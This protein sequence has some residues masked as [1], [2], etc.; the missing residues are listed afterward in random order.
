VY[1]VSVSGRQKIYAGW[2]GGYPNHYMFSESWVYASATTGFHSPRWTLSKHCLHVNQRDAQ[3]LGTKAYPGSYK[4]PEGRY[5]LNQIVLVDPKGKRY[6]NLTS[7]SVV[8]LRPS[9]FWTVQ[10]DLQHNYY[11]GWSEDSGN[12]TLLDQMTFRIGSCP[13]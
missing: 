4:F 1:Q 11:S 10:I 6:T 2:D 8:R 12:W 13:P 7:G 5:P 9:G 3:K